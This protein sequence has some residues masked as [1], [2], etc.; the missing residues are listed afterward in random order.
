MQMILL[1]LRYF[2]IFPYKSIWKHGLCTVGP[3]PVKKGIIYIIRI[4]ELQSWEKLHQYLF[5]VAVHILLQM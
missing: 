5:I 3:V 1:V 4:R 2:N